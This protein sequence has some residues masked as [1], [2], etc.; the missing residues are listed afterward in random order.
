MGLLYIIALNLSGFC[1]ESAIYD[2]FFHIIGLIAMGLAGVISISSHK[3]IQ[4]II[5]SKKDRL[6]E[7]DAA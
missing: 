6:G 5:E 3:G 4:M 1:L 2:N 7:I